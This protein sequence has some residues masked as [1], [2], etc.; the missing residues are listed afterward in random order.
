MTTKNVSIT[1]KTFAA[2]REVADA[3]IVLDIAE[4]ATIRMLLDML[5]ARYG[6]LGGIIF[7]EAGELRNKVNI[8]KNG[9]NVH[10]LKGLDTEIEDGD[11]IALF[12][13]VAGG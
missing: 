12:P 5:T 13:P 2:I 1:V 9:R 6:G 7:A 3:A 10:F 11:I 8:L 4:G